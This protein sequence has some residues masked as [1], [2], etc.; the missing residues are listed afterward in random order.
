MVYRLLGWGVAGRA[1]HKIQIASCASTKTM[2]LVQRL[3]NIPS[4]GGIQAS[5]TTLTLFYPFLVNK[6]D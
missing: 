4:L 3:R 6:I 1:Y 5:K 2:E